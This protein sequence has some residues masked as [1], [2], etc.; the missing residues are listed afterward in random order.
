MTHLR[1]NKKKS[2]F[3]I[4]LIAT[5]VLGA[6]LLLYTPSRTVITGVVYQ[7]VPRAWGFGEQVGDTWSGFVV[8]FKLKRSLSHENEMLHNE[9][10]R[11]QALVLDRNLLEEKVSKLEEI[12]GRTVGDDRVVGQVLV[13]PGWSTYDTLILDVGEENGINLGD[14]VVYAGSSVVGEIVEVYADSS[15]V[16]LYSSPGNEYAVVVGPRAIPGKAHGRGMG[17]FE[18]TL[19]HGSAVARGDTV[20]IPGKG[21]VLGTIEEIEENIAEGAVRI[22]FQSPWNVAE[23]QTVEVLVRR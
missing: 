11:M 7:T 14:R 4:A 16:N 3:E 15:K 20:R 10:L 23:M 2:R 6:L 18:L 12:L 8:N 9:I 22:L 19:P 13:V 21:Y 1:V 17:N 5:M